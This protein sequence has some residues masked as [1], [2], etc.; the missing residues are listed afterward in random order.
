MSEFYKKLVDLYAGGEL[1]VELNDQM[2]L[3]GAKDAQL[4]VQMSTLRNTVDLL[5][6][7]TG[8]N[9]S[10][11]SYERILQQIYSRADATP[12]SRENSHLQYRLPIQ[13]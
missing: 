7:D 12:D 10:E 8:P 5:K 2:E 3:A 13:I 4:Q 6:S 1:P 9:F 11:E